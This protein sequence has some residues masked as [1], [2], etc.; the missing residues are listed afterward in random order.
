MINPVLLSLI[1]LCAL[2]TWLPRVLPFLFVK[3]KGLPPFLEK[4]LQFLP[5]SIIFALILSSFTQGHAGNFPRFKF[6]DLLALLPTIYV[7]FRYRNLLGT[8]IF[9]VVLMAL[10]RFFIKI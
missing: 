8:V 4:F 10:L 5:V 7:G 9:G 6:L 3:Y 1:L 2:V